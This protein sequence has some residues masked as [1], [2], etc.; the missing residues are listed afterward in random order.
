MFFIMLAIVYLVANI[1]IYLKCNAAMA[2]LPVAA[3]IAAGVIYWT[4][5]LSFIIY[6]AA[7]DRGLPARTGHAF[8]WVSTSWLVFT[9]YTL[10]W[11]IIFGIA[12]LAGL[13]VRQPFVWA[14]G[15]TLV[16]M[17]A[18][19]A[20]FATP[21][22]RRLTVD[23]PKHIDG[24]RLTRIVAVSDLHLGYGVTR[25]RLEQ[26]V[27]LINDCKP[28]IILIAGDLIDMTITPLYQE[29]MWEPLGKLHARLG[30][31]MVPGNH[32]HLCGIDACT[33]FVART[34]IT[35]LRDSVARLECGIQIVGRDDNYNRRRK[36][37]AQLMSETD[38]DKPV[39]VIDHQPNDSQVSA[40]I[41]SRA[42]LLLCGH[43]HNGQVWP[44]GLA[45]KSIY[46]HSYGYDK[47]QGT[48]IYVSSGLGLWGPPYRIGS[49]SELA[50]IDMRTE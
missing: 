39:I 32:D 45:T 11:L 21:D 36:P 10:V 38:P 14:A 34:P 15:L 4:L 40:A 13:H 41:D 46:S 28:D 6:M 9:L 43:T 27:N 3:R 49:D 24:T 35:L 48:H 50:V 20:N 31:F 1:F 22:T 5:A 18:G 12:G 2:G 8:Y 25:P 26:Y 30:I 19:F 42:D 23:V 17:A 44:F 7:G 16:I 29:K 37:L 47:V 33:Q